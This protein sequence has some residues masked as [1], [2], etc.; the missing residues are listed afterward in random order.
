MDDISAF[1][2]WASHN[3]YPNNFSFRH[4]WLSACSV[5]RGEPTVYINNAATTTKM[6]LGQ[7][8]YPDIW[9]KE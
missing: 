4:V 9:R 8:V 2:L 5:N 7:P 6:H 3:D 1:E